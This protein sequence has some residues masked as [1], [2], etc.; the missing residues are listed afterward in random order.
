[1]LEVDIGEFRTN[2]AR[3]LGVLNN[4]SMSISE[5]KQLLQFRA[6]QFINSQNILELFQTIDTVTNVSDIF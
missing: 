5:L 2:S 4:V 3:G 6:D 1:M